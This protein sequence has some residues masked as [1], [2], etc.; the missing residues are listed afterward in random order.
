MISAKHQ[1]KQEHMTGPVMLRMAVLSG[2]GKS[3]PS[4]RAGLGMSLMKEIFLL[5]SYQLLP[6]CFLNGLRGRTL[7]KSSTQ[8]KGLHHLPHF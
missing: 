4:D 5:C 3:G 8:V 6:R 2:K 1:Q 7:K